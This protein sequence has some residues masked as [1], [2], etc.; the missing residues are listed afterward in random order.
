LG[1]VLPLACDILRLKPRSF[2]RDAKDCTAKLKPPIQVIGGENIP[3]NGPCLVTV[4]HFSSPGFPSWWMTLATSAVIP[5]PVH[6]II[7]AA[8]TT[9]DPLRS[10][11]LTPVTCWLFQRIARVYD[12][13]SMPPM[14]P[15]A[16]EIEGRALAVQ[17][18]IRAVQSRKAEIVG[19]APEGGDTPGG[20][21][22]C[23]PP[24]VGRFIQLLS[25]QGLEIVPVGIYENGDRL[26]LN[27]GSRYGLKLQAGRSPEDRDG[28]ISQ[29]VMHRIA[30]LLPIDLRGEYSSIQENIK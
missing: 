2:Q 3:S 17:Q 16:W 24:G 13:T 14:P 30:A 25:K 26:Y 20:M 19:M 23:P 10:R 27:F 8:W 5:C 6:W 28:L 12:F 15:R 9:P 22:A 7:A 18:V 4:N 1:T 11:F 21:L 29:I